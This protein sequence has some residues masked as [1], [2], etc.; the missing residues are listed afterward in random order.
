MKFTVPHPS[1]VSPVE[2]DE[3]A[4]RRELKQLRIRVMQLEVENKGRQ[5]PSLKI[6]KGEHGPGCGHPNAVYV[7]DDEP[8]VECQACGTKLDPI[9]VLRQY[10]HHER[11]FCYSLEHLRKEQR[12]LAAEIKKLKALR[13][14]LRG[15]AR[16]KLP[17]PSGRYGSRPYDLRAE[18]DVAL[19][20]VLAGEKGDDHA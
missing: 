2:G 19:D 9:V 11:H 20:R 12:D 3:V 10:A 4:W 17:P 16:A 7:F 5:E 6:K 1:D 13:S 8:R 15:D 14:R 18:A